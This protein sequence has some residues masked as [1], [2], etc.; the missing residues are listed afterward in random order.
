LRDHWDAFIKGGT[1]AGLFDGESK[2][3]ERVRREVFDIPDEVWK[4]LMDL[5]KLIGELDKERYKRQEELEQ[6]IK[7]SAGLK[8]DK[9]RGIISVIKCI[10][11]D[12]RQ[13]LPGVRV[14]VT[15][16][17]PSPGCIGSLSVRVKDMGA[18]GEEELWYEISEIINRYDRMEG[19]K[20][21]Y[22]GSSIV[23]DIEHAW[24]RAIQEWERTGEPVPEGLQCA[25]FNADK[26]AKERAEKRKGRLPRPQQVRPNFCLLQ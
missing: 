8:F 16:G 7:R 4:L 20:H 23:H 2:A 10:K 24:R 11:E 6:R 5:R 15:K 22:F 3:E 18:Y 1:R 19:C 21:Q 26:L 25:K 17:G 13:E 12:I 9:N 14:S